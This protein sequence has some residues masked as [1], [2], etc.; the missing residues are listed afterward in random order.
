MRGNSVASAGFI[1]R[2]PLKGR[3]APRMVVRRSWRLAAPADQ[4]LDAVQDAVEAEVECVIY[5]FGDTI[6]SLVETGDG[7]R[8]EFA[9]AAARTVDIVIGADGIHS[10]VRQLAFHPET[11]CVRH[12]GY[13]IAGWSL[14]NTRGVDR[15]AHS[16]N[17][18]GRAAIVA[19]DG[20]DP[21]RAEAQVVFASPPVE[22][23]WWDVA[24]QK[25]LVTERFADL[26][27]HVPWLLAGLAD[28][29]ELYFDAISRVRM[30]SWHT[31]R[32]VLL[33]DAAW[34]VTL[35]GMGVGTGVVGAYVLAGELAMAGGDHHTAFPA[36]ERRM[37]AYAGR[38]QRG[39]SPGK[40]LAPATAAGCGHAIGCW[41]MGWYGN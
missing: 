27:W 24:A 39:A 15:V 25:R 34:G 11:D 30:P 28:A 10:T 37:R 20:R 17:V 7:I 19:A 12:L 22:L 2:E 14:S 9:N 31:G 33:G 35:G 36:Y 38:W 16:Y 23:G 40:F 5:V 26:G 6:T 4:L 32:A 13:Y 21:G 3:M 29:D 41:A 8:V 1:T 18:P